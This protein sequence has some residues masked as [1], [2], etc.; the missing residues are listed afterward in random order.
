M[1]K[2]N[3]K[4]FYYTT[5]L[6][7]LSIHLKS[8]ECP[9]NSFLKSLGNI[10]GDNPEIFE[11]PSDGYLIS[12]M[13]N[14]SIIIVEYDSFDI[15]QSTHSFKFQNEVMYITDLFFEN[16]NEL[17]GIARKHQG[18]V[19]GG[20]YGSVVFRYNL[21]SHNFS[22]IKYLS[23]MILTQIYNYGNQGV[24]TGTYRIGDNDYEYF[25]RLD[26][27]SGSLILEKKG[28]LKGNLE[29]VLEGDVL[30]GACRRFVGSNKYMS[31]AY[32]YDVNNG[33]LL[34]SNLIVGT[35]S[36]IRM[37]PIYPVV[38]DNNIIVLSSG[39]LNGWNVYFNGPTD[40]V[41][42]KLENNGNV[43][44]NKKYIISGYNNINKR[45]LI[46]GTD[47]YYMIVNAYVS[48]LDDIGFS[49]IIKTSFDGEVMWAKKLGIDQ[50]N[51][52]RNFIFKNEQLYV[53]ISSDYY[54]ENELLLLR[55]GVD[56]DL[57]SN[58]DYISDINVNV[59]TLNNYQNN[60][61]TSSETASINQ[62]FISTNSYVPEVE[63]GESYC[64]IQSLNATYNV[65]PPNCFGENSAS[66]NLD[67]S[68][69]L[70]PYQFN[71][72]NS[73]IGNVEDPQNL[74]SGQ[75]QVTISDANNCTLPLE[76]QIE[77]TPPIEI[78]ETHNDIHCNEES[79]GSILLQV[80]GGTPPYSFTW[81]D[82]SI[83]NVNQAQNLSSGIY[84]ISII[85]SN[86]CESSITVEIQSNPIVVSV[87]DYTFCESDTEFQ[88]SAEG[89]DEYQYIWLNPNLT[90]IATGKNITL[91]QIIAG[92]YQ[93][94]VYDSENDCSVLIPFTVHLYNS[95]MVED[96]VAT[97][98]IITILVPDNSNFEFSLDGINYQY[99]PV[100]SNLEDGTY[101]V[102]IKNGICEII[103]EVIMSSS[104]LCNLFNII[105]PNNDGKNDDWNLPFIEKYIGGTLSIYDRYGK[106][107]HKETISSNPVWNGVYDEEKSPSTSYWYII[108]LPNGEVCKG[109]V[110]I[111]NRY[112][113]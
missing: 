106:L 104:E 57:I 103:Y 93:L 4:I 81:S 16:E 67:V 95:P 22:W 84:T 35:N 9:Q 51:I 11:S 79:N 108:E 82:S 97:N 91:N 5:F 111:K 112:K 70:P 28:I 71:W 3:N 83:G 26:K 52:A 66:I 25:Q 113:K 65:I 18:F 46:K 88:L 78:S 87:S 61:N 12:G 21:D 38:D 89:S 94:E 19:V 43:V 76:I 15:L 37:Y 72:S 98:G 96:V 14:D 73:S 59:E 102:Y 24:I 49:M 55:L 85:D 7:L 68:G 74:S 34:W 29:G 105:T 1:K 90:Q 23:G 27:A 101:S 62:N 60:Y 31:S 48:T 6:M 109:Y 99:S 30:Y 75:Y 8:Q 47:G 33:N 50:K 42:T 41:M 110:I 32:A 39:D 44:W 53:T 2:L 56:G 54:S 13:R 58:C 45:G 86:Q 17:I 100:F 36:T 40:L 80:S 10:G 77:N 107:I 69:G 64:G 92:N 20:E 63:I